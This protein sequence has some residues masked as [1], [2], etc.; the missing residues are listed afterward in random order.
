MHDTSSRRVFLR[1]SAAIVGGAMVPGALAAAES[2]NYKISL[3][4]W[5]LHRT[6]GEG[7][8]KKPMLDVPKISREEF[9]IEAIEL[10]NRMLASTEKPYLDQFAKNCSAHNVKV[11]LTMV[12]GEGAIGSPREDARMEAVER[13]K[14]WVDITHDFGGHS[15]R[16]NWAGARHDVMEKPE[17]LDAFIERSVKPF[18]AL[19]DYA[20]S[21]GMNVIIENHGGPSSYPAPMK[22][23]MESVDHER[24]GTLPDF[25]NFPPDVDIYAAIDKLM[26]Y[27]KAVSAK[28]HD[29][30]DETGES[31]RIDFDRMIEIVCDKHGY[32]GYI[33][34][35]YEG[36]RLSEYEGIRRAK[37]LLEK[38]RTA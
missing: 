24:F 1:Q 22:R 8:D 21:K 27:A 2:R 34:I 10:V 29:F 26:H 5:S 15:I 17:E 33:G 35:E 30:D 13:H 20:D 14:K 6:I 31:I 25:G 9:D 7:D 4:G 19:C 28:C 32:D 18:R 16:M 23:L 36:N 37:T 3:A 38:L 12:D 11:L